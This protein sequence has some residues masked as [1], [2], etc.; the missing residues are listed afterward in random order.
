[1]G[2]RASELR[3]VLLEYLPVPVVVVRVPDG[4]VVAISAAFTRVFGYRTYE[5]V[6]HPLRDLLHRTDDG[7]RLLHRLRAVAVGEMTDVAQ[8]LV[9]RTRAGEAVP[10]LLSTIEVG[11]GEIGVVIQDRREVVTLQRKLEVA[12]QQVLQVEARRGPPDETLAHAVSQPLMAAMGNVEL[13]LLADEAPVEVAAR[14][15]RV[16][17]QLDRVRRIVGGT[18]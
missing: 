3:T 13:I 12:M 15:E 7:E 8:E 16:Y 6:E 5:A 17:E 11:P 1:M 2:V 9:L 18:R 4:Q 10:S 14:L